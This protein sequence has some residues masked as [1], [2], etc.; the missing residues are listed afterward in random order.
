[1]ILIVVYFT[2]TV[3]INELCVLCLFIVCYYIFMY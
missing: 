2:P 1:M 3:K